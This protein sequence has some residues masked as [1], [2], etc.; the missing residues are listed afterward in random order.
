MLLVSFHLSSI[1][2]TSVFVTFTLFI[3]SSVDL[4]SRFLG[5]VRRYDVKCPQTEEKGLFTMSEIPTFGIEYKV[6][7]KES[8]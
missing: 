3:F 6:K 4:R 8:P 7:V 5:F 1:E 2:Q